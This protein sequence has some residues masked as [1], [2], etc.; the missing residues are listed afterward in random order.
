MSAPEPMLSTATRSWPIG[1]DWVL[2]PKWDGFRCLIESGSDRRVRGWSRHG[3][4]LGDSMASVLA[5]C[6]SLPRATIL[7]G[8]LIALSEQDGQPVQDFAAVRRAVFNADVPSQRML[9]Y[10][11]FDVLQLEGQDV[12]G[13][14]WQERDALLRDIIHASELI[15]PV[16]TLSASAAAHAR[17]LRLGFEGSV[18]KRPRSLYSAGRRASWRKLKARHTASV[19]LRAV[20]HARDGQLFAV[21]DLNGRRVTAIAGTSTQ[22]FIGQPIELAYS[23]V[24]ADGTLREARVAA[25]KADLSRLPAA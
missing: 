22:E 14:T 10:V 24:D 13:H 16:A 7:D 19:M 18:L 25:T 6:G 2:Q 12:R 11:A 15:R 9:R 4:S 20:H 1:G 8:E 23:R 21:C 3:A 17:I 5:E